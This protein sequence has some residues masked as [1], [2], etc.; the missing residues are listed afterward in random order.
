MPFGTTAEIQGDPSG[1]KGALGLKPRHSDRS[2][3]Q[4][5]QRERISAATS[6][7]D[8]RGLPA[9]ARDGHG[10]DVMPQRTGAKQ[11]RKG[12]TTR[13]SSAAPPVQ[14]RQY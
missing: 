10:V 13:K 4:T 7:N 8:S 14:S 12:E 6:R 3:S 2:P 9:G 1:S 5:L 11:S